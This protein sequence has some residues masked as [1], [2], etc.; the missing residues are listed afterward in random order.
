M[1]DAQKYTILGQV[2]AGR[3]PPAEQ[4]MQDAQNYDISGQ[5]GAGRLPSADQL[6]RMRRTLL[7]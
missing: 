6:M 2:G 1:E 7:L 5:V 3:F 4:L